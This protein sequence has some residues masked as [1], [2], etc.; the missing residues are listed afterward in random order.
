MIG[1]DTGALQAHMSAGLLVQAYISVGRMFLRSLSL[2]KWHLAMT[3]RDDG[4]TFKQSRA[5][6]VTY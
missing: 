6:I 4:G 5:E 1:T 2:F 3:R